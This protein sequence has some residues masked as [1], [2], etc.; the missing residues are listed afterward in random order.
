MRQL[1]MKYAGGIVRHLGLQNYKG[2]VSALAELIANA[3]DADA[4]EVNVQLPLDTPIDS[5]RTI[6]VRD[7]GRGMTWTDCDEK[8]LVIGRNRRKAEGKATSP[9]GRPLMAHKGLG[10][11]AGFGIASTVEVKTIS[12][13]KLTL[14]VMD[15]SVID[16]LNQGEPY[17]PRMISDEED[18]EERDSTE[19]V[20][21][22][23]NLNET[24]KKEYFMTRMA[25]KFGILS[26]KFT[27]YV[28]GEPLSKERVPLEFHFPEK[29]GDD[30]AEIIDGWGVTDLPPE[31]R[32]WIGF[33]ENPIRVE[34]VRGVSVITNGR[35][36][37]EP[38]DFDLEGGTWGQHGLR[39]MTGEIVAD[40]LDDGLEKESDLILTNRSAIMWDN[41]KAKPLYEWARQKIKPLLAEWADRRGVK[42]LQ[43]VQEQYPGL[44][45][46][47][48]QF[49]PREKKELVS[50]M[51][52]LAQVQTIEPDKLAEIFEYVIDGYKDKAFADM[53]ESIKEMPP[54]EQ[55]RTL[56]ILREFDVLEAVRVYRIVVSH[57]SVIRAFEEMIEKGVPEKPDMHEHIRKY[58]W[59]LG[60][61]YESMDYDRSLQTILEKRFGVKAAEAGGKN[62]PDFVCLRGG[63]DVLV[64]ELKR[65]G[66]TVGSTELDQIAGYVDYLREWAGTGSSEKLVGHVVRPDDIEGYLIA[67]DYRK[68]ATVTSQIRRLEIDKI[69][70]C[71]WYDILKSAEQDHKEF[72]Q[73]VQSRAPEDDARIVELKERKIA[74]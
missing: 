69:H 40:F 13:R 59:L 72:L 24:I 60:I 73:I 26:D 21:K 53:L 56:E 15:F 3:W 9:G 6:S 44:M 33:T 19:V 58:P 43:R 22:D 48:D 14:F 63:G 45:K 23:L 31:I 62:R 4:T 2:P 5:T 57:V 42:T 1:K 29:E 30:V 36:S 7:N 47:I 52:S 34:G 55:V 10:K 35:L 65:P 11:L 27:V 71:K 32:W 18:T 38:W 67:Y 70:A 49:Q 20:L 68:E 46:K 50:A 64:I 51:R 25:A 61:K 28:N 54:E 41:P 17:L 8:Y 37:Q 16:R 66:E 74:E 39:Y 12:G